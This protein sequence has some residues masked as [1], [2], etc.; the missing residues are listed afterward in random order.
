MSL[1]LWEVREELALAERML[2]QWAEDNNG[3]LSGCPI[4]DIIDRL[5]L[6]RD[7]KALALAVWVKNLRAL[8][9]ALA[10]EAKSLAARKRRVEAKAERVLA[11][12]EGVLPVG[13]KVED[14][15]AAISW[16]KSTGV[17]LD[18]PVEEL[19]DPYIRR[20]IEVE[21]DKRALKEALEAGSP[22]A[23]GCAHLETRHNLQV[24]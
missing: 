5:E 15:R 23:R 16:R 12:I 6:D 9:E 7:E 17:I 2:D 8:S 18:R 4:Q 10:A 3:D 21:P 24:K 13:R 19:P 22:T 20:K 1:S 11:F 14:G